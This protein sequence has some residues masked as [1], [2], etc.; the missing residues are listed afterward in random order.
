[1]M[2]LSITDDEI[3]IE[4]DESCRDFPGDPSRGGEVAICIS[5]VEFCI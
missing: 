4:N 3:C 5:N 2:N 1:M